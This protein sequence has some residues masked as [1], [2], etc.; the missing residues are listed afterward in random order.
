[1]EILNYTTHKLFELRETGI[2]ISRKNAQ[3]KAWITRKN[4]KIPC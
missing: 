1:M 4:K 3:L 2:Y